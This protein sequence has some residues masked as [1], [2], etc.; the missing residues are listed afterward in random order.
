MITLVYRDRLEDQSMPG[1]RF[2]AC[3]LQS[4]YAMALTSDSQHPEEQSLETLMEVR[5]SFFSRHK[6]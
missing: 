6:S 5:A 4:N 2:D 3:V 1:Q